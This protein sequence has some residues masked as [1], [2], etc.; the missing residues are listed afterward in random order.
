[1]VRHIVFFK[2]NSFDTLKIEF[3]EKLTK[4]KTDIDYIVDLEVGIDFL[5]SE[6]SFDATLV[7]LLKNREDLARYANDPMHTPVVSW[8]KSNNFETKVVDY[9]L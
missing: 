6:R 1:M 5:R 3:I 2:H 7:V 4:L 8:I 9:D